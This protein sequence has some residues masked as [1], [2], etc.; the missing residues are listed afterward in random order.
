MIKIKKLIESVK[1]RESKV[2]AFYMGLGEISADDTPVR[3]GV[4]GSTFNFID[5]DMGHFDL[6]NNY[7]KK[8]W[9]IPR[10]FDD[11][12]MYPRG[13]VIFDKE[14]NKYVII[15]DKKIINNKSAIAKVTDTFNL[16]SG[17]YILKSDSHYK[18]ATGIDID[19]RELL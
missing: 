14:Q 16:K 12:S 7:T 5:G 19:R 3:D 10:A 11:Y 18:S 1:L 13:R 17:S 15:A 4:Q 2:G 6:W 9:N 8:Q